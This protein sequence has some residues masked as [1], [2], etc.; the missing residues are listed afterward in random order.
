MRDDQP[1]PDGA[2]VEHA[3]RRWGATAFAFDVLQ[4]PDQYEFFASRSVPGALVPY[5]VLGRTDV[6]VGE[7]LAPPERMADVVAEFTIAR[8]AAGR[9]ILGFLASEA[10][11][12]ALVAQGGGAAQLTAEPEIDPA[13]YE[14]SGGSAKKLRA[15]VRRLRRAGID[16]CELPRM[17]V[18]PPELRR[19]V[20]TLTREWIARGTARRAHFLE[21]DAWKRLEEKRLFAVFDPKDGDRLFALLI[22]HP[23]Y[24]ENGWHLCHLIR[25]P[26]APKGVNELAVMGAIERL[27][28]EGVR[29]ATFG[30][31][32]VPHAGEFL[33]FSP[34]M[35]RV[36]RGAYELAATAGGYAGSVEFYR[37]V[38]SGPWLPRYIAFAPRGVALRPFLTAAR[39]T[40]A[41]G[42]VRRD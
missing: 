42:F 38:Q 17:R 28:D 29:Y 6:V 14:P 30:P 41:L 1:W 15:Y 10:F 40:H 7:A 24:A 20:E 8:R 33:G 25:S 5:R 32:A 39:L 16:A 34:I 9:R 37:K 13:T 4:S 21:V 26:D 11:A 22:A 3:V 36:I 2:A 27:A 18:A 31:F 23:V 12:K 19:S 35:E